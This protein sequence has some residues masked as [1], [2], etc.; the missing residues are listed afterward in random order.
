MQVLDDDNYCSKVS[1]L[2]RFVADHVAAFQLEMSASGG[3]MALVKIGVLS[4]LLVQKYKL[5]CAVVVT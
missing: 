5:G 4:I 3:I 1:C 2:L